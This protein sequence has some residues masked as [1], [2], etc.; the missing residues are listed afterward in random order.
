MSEHRRKPPRPIGRGRSAWRAA[1]GRNAR[2]TTNAGIPRGVKGALIGGT[3]AAAFGAAC[4]GGYALLQGTPNGGSAG[5][6]APALAQAR[7]S[8]TIAA[9]SAGDVANT[10][11]DFL[12]A[13]S[14][15]DTAKAAGLTDDASQA[16]SQLAAF[17]TQLHATSVTFTG[18]PATGTSVPFSAEARFDQ[19]GRSSSWSYD[20]TL[21]V[22]RDTA[23][24]R[25]VVKWAPTVVYPKLSAGQTLQTDRS[26]PPPPQVVDRN[27]SVLTASRYPSLG[28]IL[29]QLQQAYDTATGGTPGTEIRVRRADGTPGQVLRV[30]SQGAPGKPLTTTIDAHIQ[31]AAEK[32]IT[33]KGP[34]ASTVVIQPS[35]GAILA[36]ANQPAVGFDKAM[37]GN[38][39]PGSTFKL[40]TAS[41][42]LETGKV[43]P[44]KPL[45]C[46]KYLQ[47]GGQ[48]FH[49]V[50]NFSRQNPT[51]A[52]DFADSC[53]TAFISTANFL[54]DD[55]VANEARD[56]FGIG[57]NWNV[58]VPSNDGSVPAATGAMKAMS[59]IGQGN[60]VMSP[61]TMAS[62]VST[63]KAGSFHQPYI[64][65]Q[66]LDGRTFAQA[67]RS[68]PASVA[69][70]VRSMMQLTARSGTAAPAMTQL[71][72]DVGAKTGTAEVD[73]QTKPNSWFIAYDGDIAAAATVPNSG[74]GYQYAGPIVAAVLKAAS[75]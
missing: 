33:T 8:K 1:M 13:W 62:V 29:S 3:C 27:G 40:I 69:A 67:S 34:D 38:Y 39:A 25:P 26:A 64:V 12:A 52:L 18:K 53:N 20:S 41:T 9:L 71:S 74:E 32:A 28:S 16:S 11:H 44:D 68:L 35:T 65:P 45:P 66:S 43:A 4:Y 70:D 73:G 56:V 15:G 47:Y 61:L 75:G 30:L 48:T 31:A 5:H 6:D 23:T 21:T 60:D 42:A 49:N 37:S 36:V 10:A 2:Y 57:M 72:G 17:R 14:S 51:M 22:T 58:G 50:D 46:P 54:P 7:T 19:G 55:A 63:V 24:G 59:Y